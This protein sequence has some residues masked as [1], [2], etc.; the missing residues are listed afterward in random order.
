M[1]LAR[2]IIGHFKPYWISVVLA[3]VFALIG[4]A[5]TILPPILTG[6]LVDD[7]LKNDSVQLLPWIIGGFIFA[8][9]GKVVFESLQEYIQIK[10]GLDV[11]TDM[12]LRAF[13]KLHKAPMS[14]SAHTK[15]RYALQA[16]P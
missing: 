10:V 13:K 2:E 16:D 12:Q 15:G 14:F 3:V 1:K 4:G 7:V 8:Y 11:I 9:V 6:K 5:F